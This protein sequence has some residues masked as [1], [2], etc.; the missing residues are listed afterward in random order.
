MSPLFG[1]GVKIP[2]L[3]IIIAI[4]LFSAN[5]AVVEPTQE[6]QQQPLMDST[7]DSDNDPEEATAVAVGSDLRSDLYSPGNVQK[8]DG[9]GISQLE[10]V[11][12]SMLPTLS[13]GDVIYIAANETFETI[14]PGKV[15]VFRTLNDSYQSVFVAH[16][17][18]ELLLSPTIQEEDNTATT[19]WLASGDADPRPNFND[20]VLESNYIGTALEVAKK[21]TSFAQPIEPTPPKATIITTLNEDEERDVISSD[22]EDISDLAET[23]TSTI[24]EEESGSDGNIDTL[25]SEDEPPQDEP[26]ITTRPPSPPSGETSLPPA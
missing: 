17:I 18:Q 16:R 19:L 12:D 26:L 22:D 5:V 4:F 13:T 23:I 7:F 15:V 1:V 8:I 20:L 9:K 21:G 2:Y 25:L 11:G 10:I 24:I 14:Q 6:E 3:M